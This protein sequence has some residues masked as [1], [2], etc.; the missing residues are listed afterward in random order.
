[1]HFLRSFSFIFL[2]VI[3]PAASAQGIW[4]QKTNVPGGQYN[5]EF[6]TGFAIGDK[7][8]VALGDTSLCTYTTAVYEYDPVNDS[9]AAKAPYP[10]PG[11]V[12]SNSFVIGNYAY[13]GNG[14]GAPTGTQN[15]F[16]RFDPV[17]NSWSSIA[18][19]PGIGRTA[20]AAFSIGQKGY[21]V[22][23]YH[24]DGATGYIDTCFSDLWEYDPAVDQ[25][26]QKSSFPG[27]DRGALTAFVI[28][29][30]A[31][32]GSGQNCNTNY[33]ENDMWEYDPATDTWTRVADYC[34]P[35]IMGTAS[36]VINNI[37]HMVAG[38]PDSVMTINQVRTYFPSTDTWIFNTPYPGVHNFSL[39]SFVIGNKGY[40]GGGYN[41]E[42]WEFDPASTG[43][44]ENYLTPNTFVS[45]NPSAGDITIYADTEE[46]DCIVK[47]YDMSGRKVKE[48]EAESFP[49]WYDL[50]ELSA[51][52]YQYTIIS[53]SRLVTKGRFVIGR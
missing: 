6:A 2:L 42:H 14:Y 13:V 26:T 18:P 34:G 1:M 10:V 23:G 53:S 4:T 3:P 11:R 20:A 46:K 36:L 38:Y 47:V 49:V 51:G 40:A 17:A 9:W 15:T 52:A 24:H 19:M 50:S 37:A 29:Q 39:Y 16:F 22:A 43:I 25:W 32:I 41:C 44:T 7:G 35:G 27:G 33:Y 45:P 31:Y 30:K 21:I 12:F 5:L 8:Y 48:L 28:G